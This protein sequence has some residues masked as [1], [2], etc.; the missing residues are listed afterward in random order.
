ME[1]LK[2]NWTQLHLNEFIVQL[3]SMYFIYIEPRYVLIS[4]TYNFEM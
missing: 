2:I 1:M 4:I 3:Q